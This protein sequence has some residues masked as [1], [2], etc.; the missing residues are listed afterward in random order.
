MAGHYFL[1]EAGYSLFTAISR[2]PE[3]YSFS[4]LLG[5][6][7]SF[8][9]NKRSGSMK[10][11]THLQVVSV[12][13]SAWNFTSNLIVLLIGIVLGVVQLGTTVE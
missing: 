7:G 2:P 6:R 13:F 4:F 10:H 5:T 9:S 12:I 3:A 8:P 1:A 11:T